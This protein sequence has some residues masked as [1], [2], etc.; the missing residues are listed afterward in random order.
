MGEKTGVDDGKGQGKACHHEAMAKMREDYSR[1][2]ADRKAHQGWT[3]ADADEL[4]AQIAAAQS[5]PEAMAAWQLFLAT[6]V[7]VIRSRS[8]TAACRAAEARIH[9]A[10]AERREEDA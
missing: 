1:F 7:A 5:D 4:G 6:E 8:A 3:K 10:A 9:A 2:I